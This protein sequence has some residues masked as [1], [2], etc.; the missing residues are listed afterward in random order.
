MIESAW[1]LREGDAERV[2]AVGH[3]APIEPQTLLYLDR[4]GLIGKDVLRPFDQRHDGCLL[5]EGAASLVLET[6]A[7]ALAPIRYTALLWAALLGFLV[8][9]EVPELWLLAGAVVIIG[10]S[11]YMIRAERRA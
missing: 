6:E 2:V 11:L 9:G 4:V 10:S 8:W 5:G 3:D 7:S 1:A